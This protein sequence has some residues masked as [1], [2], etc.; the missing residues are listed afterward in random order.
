MKYGKYC[1]CGG[2]LHLYI[3]KENPIENQHEE[4]SY[5]K[6]IKKLIKQVVQCL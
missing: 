6:A 3:K 2:K 1:L 5:L 4:V